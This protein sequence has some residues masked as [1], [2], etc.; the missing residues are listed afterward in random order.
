MLQVSEHQCRKEHEKN[1]VEVVKVR[2]HHHK[3]S[4]MLP[5]RAVLPAVSAR[6]AAE[7]K[8]GSAGEKI[9]VV[10]AAAGGLTGPKGLHDDPRG[11]DDDLLVVD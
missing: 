10:V 5:T 1:E 9:A 8:R 6:T 11:A 3:S 4:W 7:A 2:A